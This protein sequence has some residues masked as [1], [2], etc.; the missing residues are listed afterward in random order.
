MPSCSVK[1]YEAIVP[2]HVTHVEDDIYRELA[3]LVRVECEYADKYQESV[4]IN[5]DV[6]RGDWVYAVHVSAYLY[7]EAFKELWGFSTYL[8]GIAITWC[9][10]HAYDDEGTE[11]MTD[12]NLRK[13]KNLFTKW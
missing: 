6:E 7:H 1:A 4:K 11:H 9:E 13:F 12:F 8:K 10:F 5:V 2:T 3:E